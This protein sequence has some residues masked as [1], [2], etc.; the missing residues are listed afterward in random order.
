[1]SRKYAR[2]FVRLELSCIKKVSAVSFT[3]QVLRVLAFS[4]VLLRVETR[5]QLELRRVKKLGDAGPSNGTH[6]LS[7]TFSKIA[8]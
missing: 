8:T 6:F 5:S 1:M 2:S 7:Y 4:D 3:A